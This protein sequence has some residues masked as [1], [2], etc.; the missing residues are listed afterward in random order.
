MK[1]FDKTS[2]LLWKVV[3]FSKGKVIL[4]P[5]LPKSKSAESKTLVLFKLLARRFCPVR[6]LRFLRKMQLKMGIW[7]K[8]LPVFLRSWGGLSQRQH[9]QKHKQ[10]IENRKTN[11]RKTA[12]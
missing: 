2:V 7:N 11:C 3:E 10:C 12:R 1:S 6:Q 4:H 5:R 8:N 9:S